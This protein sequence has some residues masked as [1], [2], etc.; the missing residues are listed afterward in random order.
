MDRTPTGLPKARVGGGGAWKSLGPRTAPSARACKHRLR[1]GF[2][3]HLPPQGCLRNR[4]V[5]CPRGM[6]DVR[7]SGGQAWPLLPGVWPGLDNPVR[8]SSWGVGGMG[9]QGGGLTDGKESRGFPEKGWVAQFSP[10]PSTSLLPSGSS[11]AVYTPPS[12][13]PALLST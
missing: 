13:H 10:P 3:V 12:P 8:K 2:L 7:G 6:Q 11:Q 5:G 4:Q 9:T 1:A